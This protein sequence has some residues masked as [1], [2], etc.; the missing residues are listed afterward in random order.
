[1]VLNSCT[2]YTYARFILVLLYMVPRAY[3]IV[4]G[5]LLYV[6]YAG[7][8]GY[9]VKRKAFVYRDSCSAFSFAQQCRSFARYYTFSCNKKYE[10]DVIFSD[11]FDPG[12]TNNNCARHQCEKS[13]QGR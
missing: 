12:P 4:P 1:M 11:L 9:T 13:T 8:R 10:N 3:Y 2:Y 5:M 6:W 7:T